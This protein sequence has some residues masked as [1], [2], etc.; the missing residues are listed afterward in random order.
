[1]S[2]CLNPQI[3]IDYGINPETGKRLLKLAPKRADYNLRYLE[4]KHGLNN[5]L[6]IPCGECEACRRAKRQEWSV[7]CELESIYHNNS[8][9]IT[10]TYDEAHCPRKLIKRDLQKFIKSLRNSGAKFRYFGCGEYGTQTG[11]CHFHLITFGYYPADVSP[12]ARSKSDGQ[13]FTS[14]TLTDIWKKGLVTI[15][16]FERGMAAYTAGYVSKK[17]LDNPDWLEGDDVPFLLM[18]TRPGIGYQYCVDHVEE[19]YKYGH[20]QLANGFSAP[21]P[22]YFD[23]IVI[24][25]GLYD[26]ASVQ[27]ERREK[28]RQNDNHLMIKHRLENREE[29]S[30]LNRTKMRDKLYKSKRGL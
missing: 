12:F 21:I 28:S 24:N 19:I 2:L 22:H 10:L 7:R 15:Q 17:L 6:V 4:G 3:F 23:K 8:S 30:K 16:P 26:I 27:A 29:L 11:R 25:S 14:K 20:I 1:M 5:V 18:S 9:F 13:M